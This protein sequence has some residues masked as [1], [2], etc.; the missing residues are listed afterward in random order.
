MRDY[1]DYHFEDRGLGL[2]FLALVGAI[3]WWARSRKVASLLACASAIWLLVVWM[4][5]VFSQY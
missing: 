4:L 3:V 2:S 5:I 1:R